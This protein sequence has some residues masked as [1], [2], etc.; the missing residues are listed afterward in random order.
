MSQQKNKNREKHYLSQLLVS[1]ALLFCLFFVSYK[2]SAENASVWQVSSENAL[3]IGMKIWNNE[4]EGSFNGLTSWNNGETFA[5]LGIG[6]FLWYPV[7]GE[8][9]NQAGFPELLKYIE[10]H[11]GKKPNWIG[12]ICPWKTYQE[13]MAAKNDPKM[14]ELRQFLFNNIPLQVEYLVYRLEITIPELLAV[15]PENERDAI[16]KELYTLM[17]TPGGVYALVDYVNFKGDGIVAAQNKDAH[18]PPSWGLLQVLEDM[19]YAPSHLKPLEA[20]TWAAHHVLIRRVFYADPNH[21]E[22]KWLK[23]WL[24]RVDT[25]AQGS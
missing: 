15:A 1:C 6:H 21:H 16:Y 19:R 13:F 11:G 2:A 4:C 17:A 7:S 8:D 23:G 10:E 14:R 3:S 25:Y 18:A 20:F 12:P 24:K 22:E 9:S 5:S